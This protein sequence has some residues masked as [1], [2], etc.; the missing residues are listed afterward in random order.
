VNF[1]ISKNFTAKSAMFPH[2]NIHKFTWTSPD[3]KTRNQIERK[4]I[5]T[6]KVKRQKPRWTQIH[7]K[8][9]N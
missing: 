9:N 5:N 4:Y 3:G 2:R 1:D 7:N 8:R 6:E